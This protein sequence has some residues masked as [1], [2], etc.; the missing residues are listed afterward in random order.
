MAGANNSMVQQL[1]DI[2]ECPICSEPFDDPRSLPCIHAYCFK[3]IEGFSRDKKPRDEVPCPLCRKHFTIPDEGLCGLPK[4]FFIGKLMQ[5]KSFGSENTRNVCDACEADDSSDTVK[6]TATMYCVDCQERLCDDCAKGHRKYKVSRSHRQVQLNDY[7]KLNSD[8]TVCRSTPAVCDRHKDQTLGIFCSDCKTAICV[9]CYIAS[10]K[11]HDC[12][13]IND[14]NDKFRQQL[15]A[16][17][18]M[19]VSWK[20]ES[21]NSKKF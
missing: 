18:I 15:I 14:V 11:Q 2:T 1:N 13:D 17:V 8:E 6:G 19:S 21:E 20:T 12:S 4:N 3:C 5:I 7:G 10:H 16:D 9:I